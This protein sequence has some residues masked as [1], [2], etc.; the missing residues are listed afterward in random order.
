MAERV[1]HVCVF[2]A[3]GSA[4]LR[5]LRDVARRKRFKSSDG[6]LAQPIAGLAKIA[7]V[8]RVLPKS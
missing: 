7:R 4:W 6:F 5:Y 2:E 3:S 1:V 8:G